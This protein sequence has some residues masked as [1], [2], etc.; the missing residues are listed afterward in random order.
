MRAST[1]RDFAGAK[2]IDK[3]LKYRRRR[4]GVQRRN[5]ALWRGSTESP[6]FAKAKM[7]PKN[8]KQEWLLMKKT[9][10]KTVI[11]AGML[12][13]ANVYAAE[14][15]KKYALSVEDAVK[16]AKENNVSIKR[17]K[18][19]LDAALR[20]KKDS[21]NSVSPSVVVGASSTV[22]VDFLTGGDQSSDFD[23]SFGVNAGVS[24]SLSAN[25]FTSIKS[26]Q[27][28]FEQSK[29][30]FDEAVRQIELSVRQSYYGLLYEKENIG[31]QEENL[32]IAKQ[33]YESN[34]QKYNA[35]RLSEVDALSAEVNYKSKIPTVEN[36]YTTYINDLDNFKQV[37]GLAIADEIEFTGSLDDYLYLG[38]IKVEEKDVISA[39]LQT[40]ESQLESA[41]VSVMDKRF[42]AFAPS[43]N[44]KLSWQDSSWYVGKDD[45]SD[46]KKTASVSLS[47]S[48]PLDGVLPWSQKNNAI[49][50]AKDKV[51]DLELQIDN[52]RKTFVRTINSSLRSIKQSQEAIKYKQA[53][54]ELAEKNY[55][56]TSEAYNRGTKD[57]L[58]LQNSNNTLLQAKVS[59]N[60]EILTLAKTIIKLESTIGADFG[61]LTK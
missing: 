26:A 12:L 35:G 3:G 17:Q 28:D 33:Q 40:L 23:A 30:S 14:N 6:V 48:I 57:L 32:R 1:L 31:L 18:I 22:P 59:L 36:A 4:S 19:T 8:I 24:V 39:T 45:A 49:D 61:S 15:A 27:L 13:V 20:A 50:S 44:A 10:F 9:V 21:W 7:A 16:I 51:S 53:N 42:S 60:S 54:V 5:G 46:P 2:Q 55:S 25:L 29:I 47:A 38:E 43:L 56:M 41:K 34:L 52:E 11:F 58:S 37:L